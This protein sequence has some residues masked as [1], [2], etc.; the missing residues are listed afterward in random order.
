[1]EVE[2][3]QDWHFVDVW[4]HQAIPLENINSKTCLVFPEE[5]TSVMNCIVG[6]PV[7]LS[8]EVE[9]NII[10]VRASKSLENSSIQINTVNN[11]TLMEEEFLKI[12]GNSG[13]IDIKK[14]D[15]KFPYKVLVKLMQGD[16]LKD[17]VILNLG[18]KK[19]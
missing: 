12:S 16:I 14:L 10:H 6:M 3:P 18:W 13:E 19:I 11:L 2:H 9:E 4:N 1:M 17:E 15:L 5:P 7:N 8:V